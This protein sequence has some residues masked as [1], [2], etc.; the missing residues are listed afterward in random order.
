VKFG[1]RCACQIKRDAERKARFDQ[2]RPSARARGYDSKWETARRDYLAAHPAC[3]MCAASATVVDH[4]QPHKGDWK[5]FW[6]RGNWQPLCAQCHSSR[7]QS[8]ERR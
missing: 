2:T 6:N 5:V 8:L 3:V 7:K 4:I 1:E